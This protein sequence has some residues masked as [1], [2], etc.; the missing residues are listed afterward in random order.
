M[1]ENIVRYKDTLEKQISELQN[2]IMGLPEG[3]LI[4]TRSGK[5]T[6]WYIKTEGHLDYLN[7]DCREMAEA[8]AEKKYLSLKLKAIINGKDA[9]NAYIKRY[10][11]KISEA[12]D[13]LLMDPAYSE[14]FR[15]MH[16]KASDK[17]K[18]WETDYYEHNQMHQENLVY[19]TASGHVVRSKSEAIIDTGL[20]VKGIPN[21][22]ESALHLGDITFYPDFTIMHPE[23]NDLLFW[24][25]FGMMDNRKYASNTYEKL[26]IYGENGIFQGSNLITTF[27]TS[28]HPIDPDFV[29][30]MIEIYIER[31]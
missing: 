12:A 15:G 7:K 31:L 24:E 23:K 19:R 4:C 8:L 14:L 11:R 21:R 30:K 26:R 3:E 22:Y 25:H 9:G 17:V 13:R 1:Y 29:N 28:N 27:E 6:K 20:F 16:L 10:D 18:K 2:R 5:Y